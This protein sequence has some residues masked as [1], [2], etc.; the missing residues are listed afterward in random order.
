VPLYEQ[1]RAASSCQNEVILPWSKDQIQD[2][3]FP[4]NRRVFEEAT[5]PLGGLA[6]ESRSG[7]ANGQWFRVLLGGPTYAYPLGTDRYFLTSA[8]LLGANPRKPEQ[9]TPLR[10]DVPCETQQQP[11]LRSEPIDVGPG[12]KVEISPDNAGAYQQI[13]QKAADF[14]QQNLKQQG[15]GDKYKVSTTPLRA[16]QLD[17]VKATAQQAVKG[18]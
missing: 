1:V 6:G 8:P 10:P 7:D 5:K 13:V 9:Q 16:D 4:A 14:L 17:Q 2:K 12:K 15:L 3:T 18:G 11:D